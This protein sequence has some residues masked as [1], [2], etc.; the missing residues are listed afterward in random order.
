MKI[1]NKKKF[2]IRI[3]EILIIIATIIFTILAI[4]YANKVRGYDAVGGE[5][6]IPLLAF[7]IIMLIESIYEAGEELKKAQQ[8]GK[9]GKN[10]RR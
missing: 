5:Y 3:I 4:N 2:A 9:H 6:L 8:G 1:S 10:H 7:L